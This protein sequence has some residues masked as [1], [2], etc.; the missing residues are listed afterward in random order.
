MQYEYPRLKYL[1]SC[2][3]HQDWVHDIDCNNEK[4]LWQF[5]F[6]EENIDRDEELEN[7]IANLLSCEDDNIHQTLSGYQ[8]MGRY[9][10]TP[11]DAQ[12][13]LLQLYEFVYTKNT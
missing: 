12:I 4:V 13:W 7:D 5:F 9:W 1:M 8:S 10:K 2:Y 11:K 3:Y 6:T